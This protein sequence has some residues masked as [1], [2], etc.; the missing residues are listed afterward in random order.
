VRIVFYI[1]ETGR[2]GFTKLLSQ[3]DNS[4]ADVGV[5]NLSSAV[6]ANRFMVLASLIHR[7]DEKNM[8][9]GFKVMKELKPN[10]EL[11]YKSDT[12]AIKTC[13]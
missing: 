5:N 8:E 12:M 11:L 2:V 7:E 1:Q 6:S 3:K 4:Q 10:M 13:H 9:P